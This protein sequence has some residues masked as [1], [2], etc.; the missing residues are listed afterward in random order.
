METTSNPEVAALE[1]FWSALNLHLGSKADSHSQFQK[2]Q[3][4]YSDPARHYHTLR[5]IYQGIHELNEVQNEVNDYFSIV[6]A[7]FYHDISATEEESAQI[8]LEACEKSGYS[9]SFKLQVIQLILATKHTSAVD[10][11]K[12]DTQVIRDIDLSILG[13]PKNIFDEYE[14]QIAQEYS[15]VKP[16][17][18]YLAK[19]L[20]VIDTFIRRTPLFLT[21]HFYEKYEA[22]AKINLAR[23]ISK[24]VIA[25]KALKA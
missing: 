25:R 10:L 6:Y 9:S 16:P 20:E 12:P 1:T 13:Q 5:H 7:F 14:A 22:Q 17:D 2:I 24:I 3:E 19:R 8:A 23:S 11:D 15:W 18:L 21:P 4:A